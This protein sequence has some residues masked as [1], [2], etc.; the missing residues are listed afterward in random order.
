MKRLAL[1]LI[2]LYQLSLSQVMPPACRFT[3][4]C[5]H[6]T[7]EAISRFG[8]FKGI[9]LGMKRLARCHPLHKG[10]YDPV[11]EHGGIDTDV[12]SKFSVRGSK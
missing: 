3:P 8:L 1:K 9:Y 6:Y 2:R 5:S 11:P 7:Y 12:S 10:G 4:T